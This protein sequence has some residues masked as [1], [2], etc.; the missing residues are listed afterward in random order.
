MHITVSG[1]QFDVGEALT[2]RVTD[3]LETLAGKYWEHALEAQV[4]FSK[5]RAFVHCDVSVHAGRGITMRGA[6]EGVDAHTAFDAAAEHVG[7]RLRRY[8]R[9][10]SDHHRDLAARARPEVS[11][12]VIYAGSGD[13]AEEMAHAGAAVLEPPSEH[14]AGEANGTVVAEMP[15]EILQL[16]VGDAVMRMDLEDAPVLMFRNRATGELNVVYRR[17]DGHIGWIDPAAR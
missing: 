17:R 10:L 4:T 13:E 15:G 2:Q 12:E 3:Q 7:K 14:P 16:S 9:R 6:G 1:R 5:Q 8:R 11:R